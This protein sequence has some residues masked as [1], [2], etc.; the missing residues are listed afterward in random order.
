M[1]LAMLGPWIFFLEGS[2]SIKVSF[3][4]PIFAKSEAKTEPVQTLVEML[5]KSQMSNAF[6]KF[7]LR[8]R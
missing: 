3:Q 5:S 7:D 6:W 4:C 8:D 1:E 2:G